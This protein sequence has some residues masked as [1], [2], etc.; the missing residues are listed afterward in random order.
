M[1][2]KSKEGS[3]GLMKRRAEDKRGMENV[4]FLRPVI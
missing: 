1:L 2:N 4:G 3:Y